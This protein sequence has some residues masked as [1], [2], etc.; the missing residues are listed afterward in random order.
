MLKRRNID[1]LRTRLDMFNPIRIEFS[2][3]QKRPLFNELSLLTW[4]LFAI[5]HSPIEIEPRIEPVIG[6]MKMSLRTMVVGV[7][8]NYDTEKPANTRHDTTFH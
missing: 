2:T 5:A 6:R 4:E 3:S 1:G 8:V 7:H